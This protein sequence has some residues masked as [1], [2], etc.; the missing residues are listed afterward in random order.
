MEKK[1][2]LFKNSTKGNEVSAEK[3]TDNFVTVSHNGDRIL[4]GLMSVE[5]PEEDLKLNRSKNEKVSKNEK[6]CKKGCKGCKMGL[7]KETCG[8]VS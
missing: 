2:V 1:N 7:K 4:N 8:I 5:L 6:T 3:M